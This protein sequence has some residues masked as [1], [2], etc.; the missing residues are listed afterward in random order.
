ML[1]YQTEQSIQTYPAV[2][3]RYKHKQSTVTVQVLSFNTTGHHIVNQTLHYSG[4]NP[5]KW[6]WNCIVWS[7]PKWVPFND[8]WMIWSPKWLPS[9]TPG[10]TRRLPLLLSSAYP[11]AA[12]VTPMGCT[13]GGCC[14]G[15]F[16]GNLRDI[17]MY[18]QRDKL[19]WIHS[20][21]HE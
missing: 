18:K 8:P 9:P 20:I 21:L 17:Q 16:L 12:T 3:K 5:S 11:R 4:E 19:W 13:P 2:R 15:V 7:P 14:R 6:P 10:I 1:Q